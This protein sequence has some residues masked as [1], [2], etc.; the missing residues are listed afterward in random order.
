MITPAA[1]NNLS[2]AVPTAIAIE[3]TAMQIGGS[4]ASRSS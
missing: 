2:V 4:R 3:P 1:Q